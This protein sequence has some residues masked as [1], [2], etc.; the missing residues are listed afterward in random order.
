MNLHTQMNEGIITEKEYRDLLAI[1]QGFRNHADKL[2]KYRGNYRHKHAEK[3]RDYKL[4]WAHKNGLTKPMS[5]NKE[6]ALYLGVHIAERILSKIFID[7]HRMPNGNKGFDFICSKGYK[8]DVKSACLSE[9]IWHFQINK[10]EI[11]DYFLYLAFDDRKNLNPK[12]IW[13]IPN[14]FYK[15]S[16]AITNSQKVLLKWQK[17]EQTDKLDKLIGCCNILKEHT[18]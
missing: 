13:L 3:I 6:C 18:T 14:I 12:Y 1:Q 11:P 10:N 9:N 8:I 7:V 2:F 16:I 15:N 4:E 17:Y 5:E